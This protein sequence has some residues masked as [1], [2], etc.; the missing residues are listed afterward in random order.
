MPLLPILK[1]H[2]VGVRREPFGLRRLWVSAERFEEQMAYL[3][4]NGYRTLSLRECI[5]YLT[6]LDTPPK[7]SV[8]LTFDDG[9]TNFREHAFPILKR[10]GFTASVF[11]VTREAGGT[12]RWDP[13]W[14]FPL[15][16]WDEI[17]DLSRQGVEIGS[18]TVS[19]PHLTQLSLKEAKDEL[20][21]SR[22]VLEDKLNQ[23]VHTLLYPYGD[24]NSGIESLAAEAGYALA[25]TIDRGNL[26]S[27][28]T[29]LRLKRVPMDEFTTLPRLRRRLSP[30][31]H[32][33]CRLLALS[34]KIRTRLQEAGV[35]IR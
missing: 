11:I 30:L 16:G 8:V 10:Y 31:Y 14:D 2:H 20:Q 4:H 25:C 6:G 28:D 24:T 34:R 12:S 32:Y 9:F 26:H 3:A 19:H 35:R 1:F 17:L 7:R 5:P 29:R 23:P 22:D 27:P 21:K 15:M 18:H 13:G 33:S